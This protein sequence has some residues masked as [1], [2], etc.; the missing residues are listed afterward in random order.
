MAANGNKIMNETNLQLD[1]LQRVYL[2]AESTNSIVTTVR[3]W[4]SN[5]EMTAHYGDLL[6]NSPLAREIVADLKFRLW[7]MAFT[8]DC[9]N[10]GQ[11]SCTQGLEDIEKHFESIYGVAS[12]SHGDPDCYATDMK[13]LKQVAQIATEVLRDIFKHYFFML[14]SDSAMSIPGTVIVTLNRL[15]SDLYKLSWLEQILVDVEY[16]IETNKAK[17]C[18]KVS[19]KARSF[20]HSHVR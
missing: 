3:A 8:W 1:F 19:K 2:L 20:S 18:K 15:Q 13:I 11:V 14:P 4:L 5:D 9:E 6:S 16:V 7:D 17:A 10:D 12:D